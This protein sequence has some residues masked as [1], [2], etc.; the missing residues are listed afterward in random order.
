MCRSSWLAE[1]IDEVCIQI[2]SDNPQWTFATQPPWREISGQ[3]GSL[4][5]GQLCVNTDD[6]AGGAIFIGTTPNPSRGNT[7]LECF[8][9]TSGMANCDL[10]LVDGYSLSV[11]CETTEGTIGGSVDLWSDSTHCDHVDKS[12]CI[13]DKG[14]RSAEMDVDAFFQPAIQNGNSYC[15]WWA[16]RQDLFFPV[17]QQL[18]CHVSG[19]PPT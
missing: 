8:F 13:N 3:F 12:Q 14:Y 4:T 1:S 7:K 10:S 9:P 2:T 17:T 6:E 16:C 19:T 15:I 18:R 11:A 5:N